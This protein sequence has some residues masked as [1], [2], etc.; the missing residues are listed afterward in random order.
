VYVLCSDTLMMSEAEQ[1]SLQ[2]VLA[3]LLPC[4]E[5]DTFVK[6]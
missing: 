5:D 6:V 1:R 2:S 3:A 4:G